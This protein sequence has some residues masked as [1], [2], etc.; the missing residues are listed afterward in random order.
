MKKLIF[1]YKADSGLMNFVLDA[2]HKLF[3]PATYPCNLCA[4]TYT[5]RGL[6][7]WRRFVK[8]LPWPVAFL[9][10]DELVEQYGETGAELPAAFMWDGAELH[11]WID[12]HEMNSYQTLDALMAGVVE[13]VRVKEMEV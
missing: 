5:P 7:R 2:A 10:R 12:A 4:L 3:S 13:R 8:E 1:V 11:T 6:P 9:H